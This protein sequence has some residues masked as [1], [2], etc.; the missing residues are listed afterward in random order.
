MHS[1]ASTT[2][3]QEQFEKKNYKR[4]LKAEQSSL[5]AFSLPCSQILQYPKE[6]KEKED[7]M[8]MAKALCCSHPHHWGQPD[9]E[10]QPC[11]GQSVMDLVAA[12]SITATCWQEG[13]CWREK[14]PVLCS[15][16]S[17]AKGKRISL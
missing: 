3:K 12:D 13:R 9:M 5:E 1:C 10:Q 15:F 6:G 2:C 17:L 14:E 16:C 11:C 4:S 8:R 7:G